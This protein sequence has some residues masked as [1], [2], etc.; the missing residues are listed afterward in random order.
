MLG[1]KFPTAKCEPIEPAS[2]ATQ[3]LWPMVLAAQKSVGS[4]ALRA[5][6]F[7]RIECHQGRRRGTRLHVAGT[8]IPSLGGLEL[9]FVPWAGLNCCLS[10]GRA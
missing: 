4:C 3:T 1:P 2:T 6:R 9:L 7:V 5:Q 10:P 8:K